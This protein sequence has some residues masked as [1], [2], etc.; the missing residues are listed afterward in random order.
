MPNEAEFEK[1]ILQAAL[2]VIDCFEPCGP[3]CACWFEASVPY[4]DGPYGFCTQDD[5]TTTAMKA[6]GH[7]AWKIAMQELVA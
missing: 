6:G 7:A 4:P 3:G 2:E 5:E 1:D